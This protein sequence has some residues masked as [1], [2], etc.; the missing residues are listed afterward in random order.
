MKYETLL[1]L[2][3]QNGIKGNTFN[4]TEL[5]VL[6]QAIFPPLLA[7]LCVCVS[8]ND[9]LHVLTTRVKENMIF[10]KRLALLWILFRCCLKNKIGCH[11]TRGAIYLQLY[12]FHMIM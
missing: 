4:S 6:L 3:H 8:L 2:Q 9:P 12:H 1:Y 10:T 7:C 5:G 11:S